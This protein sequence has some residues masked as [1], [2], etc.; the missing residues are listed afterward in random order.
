MSDTE[1]KTSGERIAKVL[2][3]AGVCSRR[4]AEKL[5]EAGRV[6][7]DGRTIASPALNVG[8]DA[9]IAVDGEPVQAAEPTRLWRHHKKKGRITSTRDPEGRPT[10]Y[11]DLPP[12]LP[13][14]LCVGRLD[15][16]SEG[17]LLLTNDGALARFLELPSTG[18]TRRYRVRVHGLVDEK[19]L[20]ALD[21]GV[22]VDGVK[23]EPVKA[24]LDKVQGA[25]AWLTFALKEGKNREVR[26][27]CAHLGLDVTRLIRIGYGPFQLGDMAPGATAAVPPKLLKDQLGGH[28]AKFRLPTG[29]DRRRPA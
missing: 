27:L 5:I 18:W 20:A 17:L 22:T 4:E 10:V 13:R 8:P 12:D 16:N 15:Y 11:A 24:R 25:N 23:Y 6:A 2:A 7:V 29:A 26:K 28:A 9:R 19:K 3:R 21:K 1:A 14:L